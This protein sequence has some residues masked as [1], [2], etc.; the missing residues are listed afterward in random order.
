MVYGLN[1][2][3]EEVNMEENIKKVQELLGDSEVLCQLSEECDELAKAALK[4]R[5]AH[6]GVN[7]TP[8][9]ED[10]VAT[11]L[12]EEVGDVM[13]CLDTL[14]ICVNDYAILDMREGKLERW[15][16]RLSQKRKK[17]NER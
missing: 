3:I 14:G 5:R 9:S 10:E 17:E 4:L 13:N 7:P 6:E 8:V 15:V 16:D 1:M 12:L 2:Q 11:N